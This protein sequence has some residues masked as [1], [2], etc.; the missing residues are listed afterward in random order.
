MLLNY[1]VMFGR[2]DLKSSANEA[3]TGYVYNVV[4]E[5]SLKLDRIIK[6]RIPALSK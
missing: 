6:R 1:R 2:L 3:D 5:S 4:K